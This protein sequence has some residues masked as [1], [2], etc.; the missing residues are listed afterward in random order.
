MSIHVICSLS[1]YTSCV[2]MYVSKICPTPSLSWLY[3]WMNDLIQINNRIKMLNSSL[4]C[5]IILLVFSLSRAVASPLCSVLGPIPLCCVQKMIL[6]FFTGFS[7]LAQLS[8]YRSLPNG[9]SLYF[10]LS[11]ISTPRNSFTLPNEQFVI[12]IFISNASSS[13]NLTFT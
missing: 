11:L 3:K 7:H 8:F 1:F 9:H 5:T 2:A 6:V 12:V 13:L 10:S 4:V